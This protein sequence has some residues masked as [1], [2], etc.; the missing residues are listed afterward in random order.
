LVACDSFIEDGIGTVIEEM[1]A[2]S[3]PVVGSIESAVAT[4]GTFANEIVEVEPCCLWTAKLDS[5]ICL[6][7]SGQVVT[8]RL[9]AFSG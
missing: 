7:S 5:A 6:N 2:G 9:N 3:F 8:E 1:D 4:G